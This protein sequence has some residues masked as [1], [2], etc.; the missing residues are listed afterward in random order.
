MADKRP[1]VLGLEDLIA[2]LRPVTRGTGRLDPAP[3]RDALG[4]SVA[5]AVP[6]GADP[7]AGLNWPLTE[8]ARTTETVRVYDPADATRY[9]DVERALTVTFEDVTGTEVQ[10]ILSP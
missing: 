9:V 3:T 8:T 1:Q 6:S 5:E 10:L 7:A 2:R 4:V